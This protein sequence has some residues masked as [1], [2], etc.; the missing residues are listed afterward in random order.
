M[1]RL[2]YQEIYQT[3]VEILLKYGFE[4]ED[5]QLSA[6][7]FTESNQDGVESHGLNRF[8]TYIR[9]I[10]RGY[11]KPQ[12]RAERIEQAASFERWDGNL[13]PGNINA[14]KCMQQAIC[15]AEK[16]GIGCVALRNTNHWLRGGSYGWQ[17]ADAGCMAIC[18]TN[19]K[20]NMPPWG[21]DQPLIGNNPFVL[22]IPH[23]A[24]HVV[25]DMA[26]SLYSFGKLESYRRKQAQL[27]FQGG[28]DSQGNLSCDPAE[29]EQTERV[30]P[31]GFWKGSGFSIMLDIMAVMLSQG[32]AVH[33]I[34][35]R[36]HEFGLSQVFIA[37]DMH[38]MEMIN[39]DQIIADILT[40]TKSEKEIGS[41]EGV[42]Y[43]GEQTLHRR[44]E[45]KKRGIPVDATYWK[46]I[47]HILK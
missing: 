32:D 24:G 45:N 25:L 30:L 10:Q 1:L 13:A 31:I 43:P 8:P 22:A 18:W 11:I 44:A 21:S 40:Y 15:L 4:K 47:Q 26:L 46:Q 3:L 39:K 7:L 23:S 19:T 29:I 36:E 35:S 28:Y 27:P 41:Q 38:K 33:E 12:S 42:Y 34:G 5:A 17:A 2:P 20:P 16:Q 6:T 37:F 14:Y 9:G